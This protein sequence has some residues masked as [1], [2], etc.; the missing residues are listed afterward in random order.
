MAGELQLLSLTSYSVPV[1]LNYVTGTENALHVTR[2]TEATM[3]REKR[4]EISIDDFHPRNDG[5]VQMY[6]GIWAEQGR[7]LARKTS[8]NSHI[9]P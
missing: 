3:V 5:S 9:D 1:T 4:A 2:K 7:G 6:K 8:W